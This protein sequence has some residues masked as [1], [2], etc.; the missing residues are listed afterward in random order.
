MFSSQLLLPLVPEVLAFVLKRH[1]STDRSIGYLKAKIMPFVILSFRE[2][3]VSVK[4][5]GFRKAAAIATK[6]LELGIIISCAFLYTVKTW[7]QRKRE[8]KGRREEKATIRYDSELL[9]TSVTRLGD[10][11]KISETFHSK[12][13]TNIWQVYGLF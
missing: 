8:R 7:R 9:A 12:I 1:R 4:K 6:D 10:L 11:L 2:E 5:C 13:C 3:M